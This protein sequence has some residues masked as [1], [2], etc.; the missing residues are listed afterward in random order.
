MRREKLIVPSNDK[1]LSKIFGT[2]MV[3]FSVKI[4][5]PVQ[6]ARSMR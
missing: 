1:S 3:G 2:S 6:P 4:G 5:Q